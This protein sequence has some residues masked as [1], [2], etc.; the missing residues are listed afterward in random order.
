MVDEKT[1]MPKLVLVD[2]DPIL[3]MDAIIA[4]KSKWMT[5][6]GGTMQW[7]EFVP[8]V[9]KVP[10]EFLNS[11]DGDVATSD[12]CGDH[13][14]IFLRGLVNS[15]QFREG[16]TQITT[17]VAPSNTLLVFDETGI[18]RSDIKNSK[19][20]QSEWRLFKDI[21]TK[22]GTV[23]DVPPPFNSMY[24]TQWNEKFGTGHVKAVMAEFEK[25]G[26]K[27]SAQ[28]VKEIFL[29]LVLPDWSYII[30]EIDKM[31]EL[32]PKENISEQD[33]NNIVFPWTQKHAIFEF[34]KA[35]NS[36]VYQF[37]M[38]SYDELLACK[39]PNEM[40]M[41]YCMKLLRWQLIASH[42]ISYG[43]PLPASL[44]AIANL[45]NYNSAN[46]KTAKLKAM[47]PHLFKDKPSKSSNDENNDEGITSFTANVVSGFVKNV[48]TRK[49]AVRHATLGSLPFM[50]VAM[51]RYMTM[52]NCMEES[53][54]CGDPSRARPLFR[55]A[56]Y[57]ICWR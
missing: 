37:T 28:T 25:R 51:T 10:T 23:V 4:L 20:T 5:H 50:K 7:L 54:L 44:K 49:V 38:D 39:V 46:A 24:E 11:L 26:K 48:F 19:D 1:S 13:K 36:G 32:I 18:I 45:M 57:K 16:L 41:A 17:G 56:M 53:R 22:K 52:F 9:K 31:V 15:K 33:V 35:F 8:P 30:S 2:G 27:I 40:I 47:K 43:Q 21:F 12:M 3:G 29:E 34:A 6:S 42:L 55:N 14:V